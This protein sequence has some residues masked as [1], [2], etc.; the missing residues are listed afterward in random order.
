MPFAGARHPK[1]VAGA[2]AGAEWVDVGGDD[3][4]YWRLMLDIWDQGADTLIVEHDVVCRPDVIDQLEE[5]PEPWCAFRYTDFCHPACQEAWANM[6]GC[7]RFRAELIRATR[8]AVSSIPGP[9]RDWHN[10][11]DHLAGDKTN[12]VPTPLRVGSVRA[13]GFSH[14]WHEPPVEHLTRNVDPDFWY[15]PGGRYAQR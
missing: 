8:D 5:C 6:L 15:G 3:H 14:H 1:V 12:G 2:P 7:T 13:A 4:G 11:C 10:L 9:L